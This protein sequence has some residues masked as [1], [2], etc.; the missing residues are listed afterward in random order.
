[1]VQWIHCSIYMEHRVVVPLVQG[2]REESLGFHVTAHRILK[3]FRGTSCIRINKR[4][5]NVQHAAG[6]G[7]YHRVPYIGSTRYTV[8]KSGLRWSRDAV[9]PRGT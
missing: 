7:T 1:M 4:A 3:N 9:S 5:G 8:R 2:E 6:S